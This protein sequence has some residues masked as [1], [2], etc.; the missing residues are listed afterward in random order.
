[1]S[2]KTILPGF[3]A[4]A[5]LYNSTRH[6]R[7]HSAMPVD[8]SGVEAQ[9]QFARTSGS[10]VTCY[11]DGIQTSCDT[12]D[13]CLRAGWCELVDPPFLPPPVYNLLY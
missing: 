5:S 11:L 8:R 1:M 2:T 4:E 7:G 12:V 9:S 3:T 13:T 10:Q 6:Y